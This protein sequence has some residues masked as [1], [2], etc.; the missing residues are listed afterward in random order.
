MAKAIASK[1]SFK[2]D[3]KLGSKVSIEVPELVNLN[4]PLVEIVEDDKALAHDA[5]E[6][7]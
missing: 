4:A 5:L 3:S 6:E 2:K 7:R 1:S